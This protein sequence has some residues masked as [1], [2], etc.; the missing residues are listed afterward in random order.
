MTTIE[1]IKTVIEGSET[2][3]I[4]QYSSTK[5]LT[6]EPYMIECPPTALRAGFYRTVAM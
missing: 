1:I 4:F 6:G 3:R 2:S 5:D